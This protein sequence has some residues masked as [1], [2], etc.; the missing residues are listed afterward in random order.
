MCSRKQD[1]DFVAS[2]YTS[3]LDSPYREEKKSLAINLV[4]RPALWGESGVSMMNSMLDPPY[5]VIRNFKL[6]SCA[7]NLHVEDF[8]WTRQSHSP[9]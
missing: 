4:V 3:M 9:L 2:L 6:Q 5:K 8:D 1:L 7:P